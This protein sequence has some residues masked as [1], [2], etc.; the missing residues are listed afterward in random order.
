MGF[1]ASMTLFFLVWTSFKHVVEP[2]TTTTTTSAPELCATEHSNVK[3]IV[4]TVLQVSAEA[5]VFSFLAK[6]FDCFRGLPWLRPRTPEPSSSDEKAQPLIPSR[7]KAPDPVPTPEEV[8]EGY[9][10]L[11]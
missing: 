3:A 9:S 7:A 6:V 2:T 4:S 11:V 8:E 1:V 10:I 5:V